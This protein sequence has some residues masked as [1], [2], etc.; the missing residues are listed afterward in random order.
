MVTI[1][2][3]KDWLTIICLILLLIVFVGLGIWCLISSV[4]NKIKDKL[5]NNKKEK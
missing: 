3:L 5:H 1:I 2:T 4:I